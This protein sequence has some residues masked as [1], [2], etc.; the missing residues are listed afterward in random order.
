M[1]RERGGIASFE[2]ERGIASSVV[3][4]GKGVRKCPPGGERER[5]EEVSWSLSSVVEVLI[6]YCCLHLFTSIYIYP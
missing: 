5:G 2:K 6:Y 4:V 3:V 1:L